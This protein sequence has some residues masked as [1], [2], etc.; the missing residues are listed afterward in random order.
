LYFRIILSFLLLPILFY[1]NLYGFSSEKYQ[2]NEKSCRIIDELYK[3]N[4]YDYKI[5]IDYGRCAYLR[6]DID[7]A[8]AAYDRAE[9]LNEKDAA[10][11][12]YLGDLYA[13]IGNIEIANREYDKADR[14]GK[15]PVERSLSPNYFS[16]LAH[17]SGGYDSNVKYKPELSKMQTW[18]V[19]NTAKPTSDSFIKE[20]IRLTHTYDDATSAF[21]YKSQL[22]GYN[23]NYSDLSEEDFSQVQ[24]YSGPGWASKEFDL[25]VPLSYTYMALD[26]KAYA[27]L[28]SLNPQLRKRFQNKVLLKV[29]AEYMYQKYLEWDKSNKN[30]YTAD[31]SLSKWFGHHYLRVAYQYLQAEKDVSDTPRLFIDKKL[32]QVEINY[33]VSIQKTLEAGVSYLY[34]KALYDDVAKVGNP[35]KREDVLQ[36]YSVYMSYNVTKNIGLLVQYDHY[37]NDTNYIPFAYKKEV[38]S[39][40]VYFYY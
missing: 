34:N 28:Y 31:I 3:K 19:N 29:E 1:S 6:G 40:G 32:N 12:K 22:H 8:M 38:V 14:F 5:N 39:G 10:V 15:V 21:Y 26:Y 11:H 33:K 37:D 27:K 17:F 4:P 7:R 30:I 23:K 16:I 25:W 24:I 36:K 2:I 18:D 35:D 20:Y 13:N 9:I